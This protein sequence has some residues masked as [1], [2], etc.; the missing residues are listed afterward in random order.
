MPPQPIKSGRKAKASVR[1]SITQVPDKTIRS[2]VRGGVVSSDFF[3]KHKLTIFMLLVLVI[4]YIATKYQCQTGM[5]TIQKLEKELEVVKTERIRQSSYYMSRIRE[6]SMA[7][8]ADSI[9]PGLRVQ[10]QP[11]FI[12]SMDE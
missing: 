11:P 2:F 7:A 5:E 9:R 6:S 3:Y 1:E 12:L 10:Q 8:I 4:F